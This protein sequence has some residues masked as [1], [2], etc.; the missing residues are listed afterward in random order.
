MKM[1]KGMLVT[2]HLNDFNIITDQLSS[3]EIEF[4][5]EIRALILLASFLNSLEAIRMR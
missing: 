1:S 2:Q 3:I 4:D 5:E